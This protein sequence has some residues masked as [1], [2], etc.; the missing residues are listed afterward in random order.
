MKVPLKLILDASEND[1]RLDCVVNNRLICLQFSVLDQWLIYTV[2]GKQQSS[3]V[4][5]Q[6][7]KWE[8]GT[9]KL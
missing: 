5:L 1:R 9:A 7:T 6:E 3:Y 4:F 8:G 2:V